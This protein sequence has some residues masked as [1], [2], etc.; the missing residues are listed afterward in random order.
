MQKLFI[1][2][3]ID[4]L[5]SERGESF[6]LKGIQERG[7]FNEVESK[8][9]YFDDRIM[10]TKN[11]FVTGSLI[12]YQGY[13]WFVISQIDDNNSDDKKI[14]K[15]RIRKVEQSFKVKINDNL[16]IL[17]AI[18]QPATQSVESSS[19]V[20]TWTGNLNVIIQDTDI[21]KKI[22]IN[23]EFIK[24]G[25]KWKVIGFTTEHMGLRT[26]YCEKVAFDAGDDKVNEIPA[27]NAP[28][29]TA[30]IKIL[31]ANTTV[32]EGVKQDYTVYAYD[33]SGNKLT[34]TFTTTVSKFIDGSNGNVITN[35][36]NYTF[37]AIG[38]GFSITNNEQ[39]PNGNTITIEIVDNAN[40]SNSTTMDVLLGG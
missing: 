33:A 30:T 39:N 2:T 17:P 19:L 10:I 4:F 25:A 11:L 9:D 22:N 13:N 21:A 18:F 12:S 24:M 28:S 5:L 8:I 36:G 6:T 27:S 31:P 3:M 40:T 14:Y 37:S 34:D 29:G 38:N 7:L 1:N 15:C 32:I 23:F 16:C 35:N 26:L 20:S